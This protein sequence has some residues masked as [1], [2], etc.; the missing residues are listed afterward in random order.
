MMNSSKRQR[1]DTDK[2]FDEKQIDF[3]VILGVTREEA[4]FAYLECDKNTEMAADMLKDVLAISP[5]VIETFSELI[6]T[7]ALTKDI[8]RITD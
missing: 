2:E 6:D 4:W 5:K 1:V 7:P 8:L 3:L